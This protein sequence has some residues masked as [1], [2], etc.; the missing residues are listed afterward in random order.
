MLKFRPHHLLCTLG[1]RG[2]GYSGRFVLNYLEIV[3]QLKE[4]TL[5]EIVMESASHD[6]TDASLS[7]ED[8][9]CKACPNRVG[10][11]SCK[12][13][14]KIR[15]LDLEHARIL[16]LRPGEVITWAEAKKRLTEFMTT[17]KH[18]KACQ[19][20]EWRSQGFC[21]EALEQLNKFP[22]ILNV[23]FIGFLF[24]LGSLPHTHFLSSAH[25]QESPTMNFTALD[26]LIPSILQSKKN[27]RIALFKEILQDEANQNS[28]LAR[29]K[30]TLLQQDPEFGDYALWLQAQ[31]Y[32]NSATLSLQAKKANRAIDY[33]QKSTRKFLEI[34][35]N[36]PYSPLLKQISREIAR[37]ELLQGSAYFSIKKWPNSLSAFE[38][39]FQRLST[40]S[41]LG[42]LKPEILTQYGTGCQKTVK[43]L[44]LPWLQKLYLSFSR[45]S[46]ESSLLLKFAS[47][48]QLTPKPSGT[49]R[50]SQSYKSPDPDWTLFSTG[51]DLFIKKQYEA[52][53]ESFERLLT[54]YPKST[55]R[56]KTRYWL[57]RSIQATEPSEENDIKASIHYQS[58]LLM[59]PLS[60]YALLS[61]AS[62]GLSLD[63]YID[64]RIPQATSTDPNLTPQEILRIQRAEF[65]LAQGLQPLAALELKDLRPRDAMNGA[66]VF[67]LSELQFLSG[68]YPSSIMTL[69]ELFLR[70][71]E[72]AYS[73]YVIRRYFPLVRWNVIQQYAKDFEIDPI[74]LLSLIKQESSFDRDA[75]SPA[76]AQGL[77]QIMPSTAV[78]VSP[79]VLRSD[80]K[81]E[82]VNLKIGTQYFSQLLKRFKGNVVLA[83]AGYNAGPNAADRWYR[84]NGKKLPVAEFIETIPY[85]ETRDYVGMILRNHFWY[86]KILKMPPKSIE[87]FWNPISPADN[88]NS[89]REVLQNR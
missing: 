61:A 28:A 37:C 26:E 36:Y 21:K 20:C 80:L 38:R 17:S 73:T 47:E 89:I 14:E 84:E 68:L 82:E 10:P 56:N 59:A 75:V 18:E 78:D 4:G 34:E 9:I 67:Y 57:G 22:P 66:F 87:N 62:S 54:Q 49:E 76:G 88:E 52:A 27:P 42:T 48:N 58:V 60:Y 41:L 16:K 8:S 19:S 6:A 5:I 65:L 45:A 83:L 85:R 55:H 53:T 79:R 39:A 77:M 71:Q 30:A 46:D 44:C 29:K 40:H 63:Q 25:A 70:K 51:M 7:N 24:L 64:A 50:Q 33:A 3:S 23:V 32:L 86:S 72:R 2:R 31:S 35:A 69:N 15:K 81:N 13:H 1:F 12:D 11:L 43:K 74:L